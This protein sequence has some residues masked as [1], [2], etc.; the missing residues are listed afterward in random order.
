VATRASILYF[1]V[2]DFANID[3]MYQYS[4]E[5]FVLLFQGRLK[6]AEQSEDVDHRIDIVIDDFTRFIYMNICRGL[7]ED[8]KLLFSFLVTVQI[9]RNADHC[10]FLGK[11]LLSATEWLFFLRG[12]EAGKGVL[13]DLADP[14]PCPQWVYDSRWPTA[15][16]PSRACAQT[17]PRAAS[18]RA[19]APA[20][21]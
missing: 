18:G 17:S 16:R 6:D 7:F 12:V 5:F 3:P 11:T 13:E 10:K 15:R 1:V 2:A 9:L 4:L 14:A 19:S 20:T 8:H 21:T